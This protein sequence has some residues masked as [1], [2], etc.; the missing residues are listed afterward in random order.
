MTAL[1]RTAKY[2]RVIDGIAL[3]T[4]LWNHIWDSAR[5]T[6]T[7]IIQKLKYSTTSEETLKSSG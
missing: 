5:Y 4:N 7:F 6:H 3:S 2:V 1:R